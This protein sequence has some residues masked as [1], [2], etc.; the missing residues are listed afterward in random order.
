MVLSDRYGGAK[1]PSI[2]KRTVIYVASFGLGSLV[3][4]A[5][6]SV[7]FVNL[8]EEVLPSKRIEPQS[9]EVVLTDKPIVPK[10]PSKLFRQP[11]PGTKARPSRDG[12]PQSSAKRPL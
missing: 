5:L 8:A 1:R 7:A 2:I 10:S 3:I 11:K 9:G 6:L 4:A 12:E